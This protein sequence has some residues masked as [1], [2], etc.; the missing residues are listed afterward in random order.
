MLEVEVAAMEEEAEGEAA[1]VPV[2][3]EK[4]LYNQL[5]VNLEKTL[6]VVRK[7]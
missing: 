1:D 5:D 7:I 2:E 6:L 4:S 3:P